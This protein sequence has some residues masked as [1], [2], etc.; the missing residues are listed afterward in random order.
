MEFYHGTYI[1]KAFLIAEHAELRSPWAQ[2]IAWLHE[3]YDSGKRDFKAKYG[4]LTIEEAALENIKKY[5]GDH[6]LEHRVKSVSLATKLEGTAAHYGMMYEGY[7]GGVV[8]GLE[9]KEESLKGATGNS[10]TVYV[11]KS[12]KLDAI[13]NIYL[14]PQARGSIERIRDAFS[15]WTP[16]LLELDPTAAY[17]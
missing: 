3:L 2:E 1:Q 7:E 8:L 6:E 10:Q 16:E 15:R 9:V 11:P 13:R 4:N 14:S 5:F 12:L 17:K